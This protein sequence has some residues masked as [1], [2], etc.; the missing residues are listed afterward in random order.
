MEEAGAMGSMGNGFPSMYLGVGTSKR[1]R[2]VG[3]MSISRGWVVALMGVLENSRFRN[4]T[5]APKLRMVGT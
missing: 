1:L 3:A 4:F 2:P 5:T